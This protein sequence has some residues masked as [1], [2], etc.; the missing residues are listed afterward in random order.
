M[1][2]T[3]QVDVTAHLCR[4]A[5]DNWFKQRYGWEQAP[6]AKTNAS[7]QAWQAAFQAGYDLRHE[8]ILGAMA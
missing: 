1:N 7:W 3:T 6:T 8:E 5:F 4:V 2:K